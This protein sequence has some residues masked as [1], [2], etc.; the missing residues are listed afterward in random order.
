MMMTFSWCLF[1]EIFTFH[2]LLCVLK[3]VCFQFNKVC[4]SIFMTIFFT[5][6]LYRV[7]HTVQITN[8]LNSSRSLIHCFSEMEPFQLFHFF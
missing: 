6:T 3:K 4:I 2:F 5:T 7:I 8:I 1:Y